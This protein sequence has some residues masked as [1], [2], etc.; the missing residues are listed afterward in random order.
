MS[1]QVQHQQTNSQFQIKKLSPEKMNLL[2]RTICKNATDD[3]LQ[4]FIHACNRTHLDPFMKQIYAVKRGPEGKQVMTIQTGIDGYRLIAERTGKYMPGRECTFVY[5]DNKLFSATAYVKK[6]AS[7]K[8]WHEVAHT[9]YWDEYVCRTKSGDPVSMWRDKPHIML[10]KCAEAGVLRRAFPAEVSGVYTKEE[11]EQADIEHIPNELSYD[12]EIK[13]ELVV[14]EETI[15]PQ[16]AD[17]IEKL[18]SEE[19]TQYRNDLLSFYTKVRNLPEMMEGFRDLPKRSL[20]GLLRSLERR[21]KEKSKELIL[22]DDD[23][24]GF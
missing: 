13:E 2:K 6:L 14:K 1:V 21:Q 3:E 15:S 9:V 12:E 22:K 11:M 4:L 5:K 7:D 8:Q 24:I 16:E 23:E 20:P 18:I 19:G 10:G 17:E